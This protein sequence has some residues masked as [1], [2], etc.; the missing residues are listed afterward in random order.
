MNLPRVHEHF[1]AEADD[2]DRHIRQFVPH[3]QLQTEVMLALL[4]FAPAAPLAVLDLGAGPGVLAQ[5]V[6]TRFAGAR[7]HVFD[8]AENMLAQAR[9]R[10]ARFAGRVSYQ[11]GDF[12]T[13]ALGADYDLIISGLSIHHLDHAGKRALYR[14]IQQALKPGGLF[15]NRDIVY[16][17]TAR[18]SRQYEALWRAFVRSCGADD[19]AMLERYQAEDIPAPVADHL[20]WLQEAGFVEVGCHWQYLNFAIFGGQKPA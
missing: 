12:N 1:Q 3:Y 6:L 5:A 14:R 13:D 17:A 20:A 2:Y 8:L 9:Q 18:L 7:V 15:L 16:G 19:A 10:L 4:P 11:L